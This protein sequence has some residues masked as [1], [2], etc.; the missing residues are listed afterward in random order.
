MTNV[1]E[2]RFKGFTDAW[3]QRKFENDIANIQTGTNLLGSATNTG[4]PLLKMGNVQRGYFSLDKLERLNADEKVSEQDVVQHGD[5]LFNTRNTLALVG[6]GATWFGNGGQFAFNSNIARFSFHDLDTAFFNYL[7][8]TKD[9]ISQVGARAVGTTSV[10]AV[11]PRDLDSLQYFAPSNEE[12]TRIGQFFRTL[13]NTIAIHKRKLDGLREL[14]KAYLQV[15]FP[16]AGEVVPRVRFEGFGGE[17]EQR[18]L[19]HFFTERSERSGTGELIS[20]TINS[21][22]VKASELD[23]KII[24]SEDKSNYKIV[25]VGDIAY[26]SMRMWQGASGYSLYDGILSPAYIVITPRET[27]HAPFFAYLFKKAEMIQI[28]QRNS[29]GLTSDTWNLKFPAFSQIEVLAPLIEEQKVISNFIECLDGN[30]EHQLRWVARIQQLKSAYL[31]KMF[32]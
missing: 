23:R 7:Y 13:D 4:I 20:V 10:A 8:N 11:Y 30:I 21:G 19:E 32:V 6:K 1:P 12:Q 15:L 29:Q 17:W 22:V 18:K 31:Q 26:N 16:Q 5:F 28:F 14:K 24:S 27:A 25:K 3:E 2:V 9:M